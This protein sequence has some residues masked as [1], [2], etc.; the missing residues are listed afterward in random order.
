[1]DAVKNPETTAES[2]RL[3]SSSSSSD[4]PP[5]DSYAHEDRSATL[6][7]KTQPPPTPQQA[8]HEYPPQRTVN[9]VMVAIYLAGF[10]IALDRLII[11]TAIPAITNHFNSLNDVGWYASAYLLTASGFQLFFGRLYTFYNPKWV[12]LSGI[13]IFELGSLICGVAQS[14]T[15][16]IVGRAIAGLG[17]C[18]LMSGAIILIVYTVPLHRRPAYTGFF[19]AIFGVASVVGPLLGG[20][21]TDNLSWRW[22]FYI[23]LP[24]GGLVLFIVFFFLHIPFEPRQKLTYKEQLIRLDPIGLALLMPAMTCLLLALQNGGTKWAWSSGRVIALLVVA[25]VLIIGFIGVQIWRQETAT[26]PP[27]IIRNRSVTAGTLYSF[28]TGAGM[29]IF[30]YFV[31]IWFQAI[32]GVSA[33]KSGI[34]TIPLVLGLSVAAICAGI[35]TK[36][37]GYYTPWMYVSIVITPIAAGLITTWDVHTNHPKWIGYQVMYGF[38]LGLGMQQPSVAAQ[39]VLSKKDVPTGASLIFFAQTLGGAIFSSVANNV[40]DNK[41]SQSLSAL[42]GLKGVKV[43][44]IGATDLR[45]LV[46]KELLPTVLNDYNAALRSAFYCGLG[47]SCACIVGTVLMEWRSVKQGMQTQNEVVTSKG[48]APLPDTGAQAIQEKVKETV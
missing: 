14:S 29:M 39:T 45:K 31:P 41:L 37:V 40:F 21:F 22:C 8:E 9:I 26:V 15:T 27:R 30:V 38:G 43:T 12:Y 35:L 23:N 47:V 18:A 48:E 10:L 11:A 5:K 4:A 7:E 25:I 36:K 1:M 28:C 33:E 44:Q 2:G 6:S 3:S 19:G 46:P 34:D 32:K 42:P 20:V 24:I 13:F 17:T 16:L